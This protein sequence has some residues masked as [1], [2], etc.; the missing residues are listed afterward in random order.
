VINLVQEVAFAGT[1]I[2]VKIRKRHENT[3]KLLNSMFILSYYS[4]VVYW[5]RA[6]VSK[7]QN[8][9]ALNTLNC[10]AMPTFEINFA[11][12]EGLNTYVKNDSSCQNGQYK[13][14]LSVF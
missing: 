13:Q 12:F 5:C 2:N 3:L 11:H 10:I 8:L 6:K 7:N 4:N 1:V 14:Q 9:V